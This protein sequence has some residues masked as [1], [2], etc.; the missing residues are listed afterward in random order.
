MYQLL[1]NN[2]EGYLQFLKIKQLP[3]YKITGKIAWFPDEY[4]SR[5]GL[6]P[7][8]KLERKYT[9]PDWMMDYQQD[10]SKIAIRK[11]KYCIF[12]DCGMGKTPILLEHARYAVKETGRPFLIVSP[13]MVIQQTISEAN[14]F[15]GSKYKIEQIAAKDL[16][17]FMIR[18]TGVGITNYE[19]IKDELDAGNLGGIGLD[20]SS[21][22]KSHY[23]KWGTKLIDLGKGLPYKLA[24]TG[25]PAPN[26][27][28]EY[29]NHAVFM[30]AFPT[31]NSFLAK[32]FINR[33][34]TSERWELK[35]HA[36]KAFYLSLSDWS[37][38]LVNPATYGWK[39]NTK[40]LP[41]IYTSV[42][43]VGLT[44]EQLTLARKHDDGL[45]VGMT[46]GGI[47]TRSKM[48]QLA[49]GKYN[50]KSVDTLKPRYVADLVARYPEDSIVIWCKY[51]D[52]QDK[53]AEALPDAG[54]IDG[55]T[56]YEKRA[57]IVRRFQNGEI[58]TLITKCKILGFGLNLQ[59]CT[60]MIFSG[61]HDSYE[62]YYQAVKRSNRYGSTKPL[63][64]HIPMTELERPMVENV[65]RKSANVQKD[66]E[67][68]ERIFK[69]LGHAIT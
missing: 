62:E 60:R 26:D 52:E 20:E 63:Y 3:R 31:V 61:L 4:A 8:T 41:P 33:G 45:F 14:K 66:T 9:P 32:Y 68:Q 56:P 67:E 18:G 43:E 38:F 24:A 65:L 53:L 40:T 25:T 12:M 27:R 15:Y 21:M 13:L 1:Q 34:E 39:D 7:S 29:A 55:S 69:E 37:I 46:T 58:K 64:V 42:E 50:G 35:Q 30:D 59:I 16:Q 57:E 47:V 48:G 44:D 54:N 36:V 11:Q 28:V 51:N 2:V 6:K 23:G 17:Q 10:I 22:L 19:A 5:I 49:K